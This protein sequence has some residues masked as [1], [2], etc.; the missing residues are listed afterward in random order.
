[1][2]MTRFTDAQRQSVEHL[3]G[4]LFISAGA[5]SGK[6]FTL[7]QRIAYALSPQSGPALSSIDEVLAITF[8]EKAAAEIKAR[9]RSALRAEGL[10]EEALKVDGAWISTIHGMCSRILH[11]NAL[12][13][14]L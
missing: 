2:D 11:E 6:T 3:E 4:P 5:G 12:E 7:Q 1:M 8:M 9:V 14:G 13:C 10:F